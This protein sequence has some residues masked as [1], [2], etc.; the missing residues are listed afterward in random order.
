MAL[1]SGHS[2][3]GPLWDGSLGPGSGKVALGCESLCLCYAASLDNEGRGVRSQ[4]VRVALVFRGV[5]ETVLVSILSLLRS[6]SNILFDTYT[7]LYIPYI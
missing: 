3:L 7:R 2:L 4:A 1:A 5:Y 6:F